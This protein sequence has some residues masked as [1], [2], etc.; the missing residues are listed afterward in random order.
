[1]NPFCFTT[2]AVLSAVS[3]LANG[4]WD[5][6]HML[7]SEIATQTMAPA[8]VTTV[9]T[10][11]AM[12]D[13]DFP[14]TGSITTAAIWGDLIKCNSVV[15]TFCPSTKTP[16]LNM[17]DEWHYVNLPL[18]VNGTDY[19]NLNSTTG[20]ALVKE[21]FGGQALD[22]LNK[23]LTMFSKTK[24]AHSANWALRMVLHVFGD[25][26]NPMHN[27]GGVNSVFPAG[28]L[29]GNKF[30]FKAPCVGTN[31]HAIWDSVGG[32][33]G[34]VNWSPTFTPGTADYTALQTNATALLTKYAAVQDKL[35]FASVKDVD[36][37]KFVSAMSAKPAM[38][39]QA[40]ILESYDVARH[41]AYKNIDLNC[42]LDDK[43]MCV[44]PCPSSDYV[45]ALID[46]AEASI[47][48]QGKRMSVIL[49]QFAK[50]IRALNLLSPIV[51]TTTTVSPTAGPTTSTVAP[52][53]APTSAPTPAPTNTT[54]TPAPTTTHAAC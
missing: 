4:W 27:V 33:Y 43:G 13:A 47:T 38:K 11:L 41:V 50:Q 7:V 51:P 20:D 36:Y 28:D 39:I 2:L 46:T 10:L 15:S 19:K 21:A 24:S 54:T 49:T 1:M 35:A 45:N 18:N 6:G 12:Y 42:T 26:S 48:I 22:F 25:I 53:P 14:N 31:L 3:Q 44:N 30:L 29:G 9:N 23:A 17:M 34:T 32:K 16:A 8:D 37:A 5:N 52:T 40:T